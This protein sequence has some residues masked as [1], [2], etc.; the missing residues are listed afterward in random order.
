[1]RRH[2]VRHYRHHKHPGMMKK[3]HVSKIITKHGLIIKRG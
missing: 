2:H 1:M 3:H